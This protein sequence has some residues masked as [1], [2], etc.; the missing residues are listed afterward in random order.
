MKK[1][2]LWWQLASFIFVSAAGTLLHFA[3][4]WSGESIL[5]APF[6]GVNESTWEHMKLF[7]WPMFVFSFVESSALEPSYHNFW[8]AR[9]AGALAGLFLIPALFYTYIGASGIM[10]DCVNIS[11]FFVATAAAHLINSHVLC[12]GS[13]RF[14]LPVLSIIMLCFI[15]ALF[16][17]FTFYPPEI[18]FFRDPVTGTY[19]I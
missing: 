9:L 8:C 2:V 3:Y 5:L 16:V 18:P 15:A 6:S 19:G 10:V 14:C 1:T 17:I 4:D 11:I 7:F 13:G 12:R